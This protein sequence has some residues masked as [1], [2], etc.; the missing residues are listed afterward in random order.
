MKKEKSV[1]KSTPVKKT[2]KKT[3]FSTEKFVDIENESTTKKKSKTKK[4]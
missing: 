2:T 4:K 3:N 1:T